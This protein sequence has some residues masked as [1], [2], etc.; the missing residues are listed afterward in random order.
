MKRIEGIIPTERLSKVN[1]A[2]R[3]VG[4]GGVTCFDT[5]GRGQVPIQ[6]RIAGRA[7]LFTPEFNTN[8][9]IM[10]VVKDADADKVIN[11]ILEAASTGLAGEGKVFV[12][13]VDDVIDIGSKKRG[14]EAL[15][16]LPPIWP[17]D[18][19]SDEEEKKR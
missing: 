2:L 1:D 8:S 10:V 17:P 19:P 11:A 18:V 7:G 14:E 6:Q 13:H 12:T 3:N 16:P 5:R 4:V 15:A 9:T